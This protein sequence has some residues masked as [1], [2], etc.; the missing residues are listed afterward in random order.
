MLLNLTDVSSEPLHRQMSIQL[1]RRMLEGHL[2]P[3]T[4]LPSLTAMARRQRVSRGTVELAYSEL[5]RE[6]LVELQA[7]RGPVVADLHGPERRAAAV[8]LGIGPHALLG[9]IGAFAGELVALLDRDKMCSLLLDALDTYIGPQTVV[10]AWTESPGGR[11]YVV[12]GDGSSYN[13]DVDSG[14]TLLAE[15]RNADEAISLQEGNGNPPVEGLRHRLKEIG[16]HLV[17]PL[18][19]GDGLLG[20]LALGARA[21]H[22]SYSSDDRNLIAILAHQF[23]AALAVAHL[24]VDS[25]EKRRL[26]QEL[27]TARRI[28]ANLLPGTLEDQDRLEVAAFTLPSGAIGGDLYDYFMV[29]ASHVA[30]VIADA[31]GHGVPAAMLITQLQAILKSDA[32]SGVDIGATLKH[33][34]RHLQKQAGAGFFATLFY[35]IVDVAAGVL[36]YANAGH[37]FPVIVRRNGLTIALSSTGPA[38]GVVPDL[39]HSTSRAMLN[40]GDCL[41]LYTDGITEVESA[42]GNAYGEARLKDLAI[43]CRHRSPK[44]TVAFIRNDVERFRKPESSNDDMTLVVIKINRLGVGGPHAA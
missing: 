37:D 19:H 32:A 40:E 26:E 10:I 5:A 11:R 9:A 25:I 28:Q 3:G 2:R 34:N 4:R 31:C 6:G 1:A 20:L 23:S 22:Q 24:Y 38:L 8:R 43:R 41:V 18:K 39:D 42:G 17:F 36:E 21:D 30:V 13:L 29:D 44:E 7:R 27:E 12:V 15:L 16:S 33:V 14:D 35:G